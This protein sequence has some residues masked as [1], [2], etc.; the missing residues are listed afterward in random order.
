MKKILLITALLFF[1]VGGSTKADVV[2]IYIHT[3][4]ITDNRDKGPIRHSPAKSQ[5]PI[6]AL[7]ENTIIVQTSHK[8]QPF[9][10]ELQ[11]EFGY[12]IYTVSSVS[13]FKQ[14][15]EI[16]NETLEEAVHIILTIN[17]VTYIGECRASPSLQR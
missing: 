3:A 12:T 8:G 11:D 4:S 2:Q 13:S 5:L 17:G 9:Y 15:F 14:S 1:L 6:V 16:S 7:D 10:M